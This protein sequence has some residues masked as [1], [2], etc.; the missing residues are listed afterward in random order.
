MSRVKQVFG[1]VGVI[2]GAV[3][4]LV[5]L[6]VI[7]GAWWI[8]GSITDNLL[9]VFPP[10]ET[11]LASS[12]STV[13]E[14]STY[15]ADTQTQFTQVSDAEPL[16]SALQD[17]IQQLSQYVDVAIATTDS[18]EQVATGL[19]QSV[20]PGGGETAVSKSAGRLLEAL[21]GVSD[22]LEAAETLSQQVRDGQS[23]KVD[24]LIGQL[25]I[26]QTHLDDV[27]NVIAQTENDVA[28]IKS[29][30]PRWVD[31][32]SLIVTLLFTWFG[33]AQYFLLHYSWQALRRKT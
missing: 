30:L 19:A 6:A 15:L 22:R 16:A 10:I 17:E 8:N 29:D 7:I 1:L 33:V 11:A 25:N 24:T 32:G 28:E 31:I 9:K 12:D 14:F 4:V 23:D 3:G 2:L 13:T 5:C 21:G 26:L 27:E 20:R 18:V